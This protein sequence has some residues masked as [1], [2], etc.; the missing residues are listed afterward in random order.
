M[1]RRIFLLLATIMLAT[2]TNAQSPIPIEAQM[3][4]PF[5]TITWNQSAIKRIASV[6][7]LWGTLKYFH[8]ALMKGKLDADQLLLTTV[9]P[10]LKNPSHENFVATINKMLAMLDDPTSQIKRSAEPIQQMGVIVS[11]PT[12]KPAANVSY[13]SFPQESITASFSMDSSLQDMMRKSKLMIIDLRNRSEDHSAGLR[14]YTSF[15]RP[16]ISGLVD[17]MLLLPTT[18]TAYYHA[19]LR[20]DFPDDLDVIP[21]AAREGDP[22]YWYQ[23]R[24]G[25]KNTSQGAYLAAGKPHLR[26]KRICFLVNR[27][28]NANTLKALLAL[29]NRDACYLVFDGPV[30]EYLQGS[31]Y[32]MPLADQIKV[33]VK[34]GE[35]IYEDGTLGSGP[36]RVII[37]AKQPTTDE[38]IDL[39]TKLFETTII[40]HPKKSVENTVYVRLPQQAYADSLYPQQKV[41]LLALFNFWNVI[42][43]FCPNK[44]LLKG[45]WQDKLPYFVPRFLFAKDYKSYFWLLRELSA[46]LNDG[47]AEVLYQ[48]GILPP[49]GITDYFAPMCVKYIEGKTIVVKLFSDDKSERQTG[50][51]RIGDELLDI[52]NVPIDTL[53]RRWSQYAGSSNE[54]SYRHLLH[55]VPLLSRSGDQPFT[56]LVRRQDSSQEV[57]QLR[58]V[59]KDVY[60]QAMLNVYYPP[61]PKPFWRSIDDSTGYVRLNSIYSNQVDS[62]WQALKDYKY[63]ILD[64][65]GYPRDEAIVQT[66]AAPFM[67]KR[68]TVCINS[69]PEITHPDFARNAVTLEAETVKPLARFV[70][71][72]KD[73]KFILLCGQNASQAETN[74]MAWQKLLNPV[75]IG[76]PT[77]GANGVSNTI[78]M[79]GG[80]SAKYSG[81]AVYYPDGTPNQRLGVKIDIPVSLTIQGELARQDE[82]M[83]RAIQFIKTAR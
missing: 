60:W 69:F 22:N 79:A 73:K 81:Y 42:H 49:P 76:I 36:D 63:I 12:R 53:F 38:L 71:V 17:Q 11:K 75:T 29:R 30:P 46:Q 57:I 15:V 56:V 50:R 28:N 14:Q 55:K 59:N 9:E 21:A 24:F 77:I 32:T 58:P 39:A 31:Y 68:D 43:Y 51:L 61:V 40:T 5:D 4:E 3:F 44:H 83:D 13:L 64:A 18:R 6:G 72:K 45:D 54:F 34:V 82:I 23:E 66:I 2:S 80:Y 52:D 33:N 19:F 7:Q 27:Y 1:N 78:L 47:H 35:Q 20:Q 26:T 37:S 67:T 10:L 62:V 70:S 48:Y 25:L 8:P 65:R 16:L 74:I 41:R